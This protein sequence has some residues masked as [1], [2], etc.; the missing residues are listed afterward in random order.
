M[1]REK[2]YYINIPKALRAQTLDNWMFAFVTGIRTALPSVGIV[3][4]IGIFMKKFN[5]NEDEYPIDS[6]TV[7]Y[8]KCLNNWIEYEKN[9]E[10]T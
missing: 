1:P 10:N 9:K 4:A 5:I 2:E 6:A 8:N 7:T 3:N